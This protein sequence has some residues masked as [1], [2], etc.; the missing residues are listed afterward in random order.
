[1][2]KGL[3]VWGHF[4]KTT[5]HRWFLFRKNLTCHFG[6]WNQFTIEMYLISLFSLTF[7]I[8][9]YYEIVVSSYEMTF[10]FITS[11]YKIAVLLYEM[12]FWFEMQWILFL[13]KG[14][15]LDTKLRPNGWNHFRLQNEVIS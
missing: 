12:T 1:M 8:T 6:I 2:L 5:I 15:S 9:L 10:W 14:V 4:V 13:Q 7:L 11:Y 3:E